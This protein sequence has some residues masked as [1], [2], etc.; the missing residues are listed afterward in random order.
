MTK[1]Q[2]AGHS[3]TTGLSLMGLDHGR[4]VEDGESAGCGGYISGPLFSE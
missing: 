2:E 1:D 3:Q 4:E